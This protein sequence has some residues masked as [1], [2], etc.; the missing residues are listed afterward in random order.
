MNWLRRLFSQNGYITASACE[1]DE[2]GFLSREDGRAFA[3]RECHRDLLETESVISYVRN[4][5]DFDDFCRVQI[6]FDSQE[7][8][9]YTIQLLP[10]SEREPDEMLDDAKIADV[11]RRGR[12]INAVRLY[13]HLHQCPLA[14]AIQGVAGLERNDD[15][16]GA[17]SK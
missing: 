10:L 1:D 12:R 3:A 5:E 6:S 8:G 17:N 13:R 15:N 7:R 16:G 11:A 4:A 9:T 2:D 14:E